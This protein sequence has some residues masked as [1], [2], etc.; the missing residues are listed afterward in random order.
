MGKE[1]ITQKQ[2]IAMMI[3]FIL[4]STLVLGTG[5]EAK[6]DV[7]LA[8]LLA[9][10]ITVPIYLVYSKLMSDFPGTGLYGILITVFGNI[11]GRIM[12]VPFIW[13]A[14]HIGALVM[15]N[16]TEFIE[17]VSLQETP[18]YII[19]VFMIVLCIWAVREGLEVLGRWTSIMLPII[20]F[21]IL[22]ITFLLVN[23]L[24]FEYFKPV[25]YN[26][27]K[28]VAKS[29]FSVFAFP[30]A[31]VVI[32][33]AILD[34]LRPG[35]S[36]YKVYLKSLLIGGAIILLVSVRSLL[37]L[38]VANVS[39]LHFSSYASVRLINIGNFLQRIEVSVT[40]VFFF[41][42][43]VKISACLYAASTGAARVLN[44]QNY[45]NIVAPIG[46][47]M[48]IFSIIMY[49]STAEMFDWAMEIYKYYAF[50]FE[51]A[52]PLFILITAEIKILLKKRNQLRP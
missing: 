4:G 6:Q 43:F 34:K 40:I 11:F 32:F 13:F 50:A 1:I 16:F 44:I 10:L 33:T 35:S 46:L 31:E 42:G 26:G 45:R 41:A 8:I 39:I 27:F 36:T 14:F 30:F 12:A 21:A 7:W 25:L 24:N 19:A 9:M 29:A 38:G 2:S 52:L 48:M 47:L 15:R 20:I 3:S 23:L 37:S 22:I 18:Q 17:I 51:V 28:P 5:A 49:K